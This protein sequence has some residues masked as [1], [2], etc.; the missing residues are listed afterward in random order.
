MDVRYCGY[1]CLHSTYSLYRFM[2][3]FLYTCIGICMYIYINIYTC[4]YI[5]VYV[6]LHTNFDTYIHK[7]VSGIVAASVFI[8]LIASI[9]ALWILFRLLGNSCIYY[10]YIW[11][12][13]SSWV[14]VMHF[15][16]ILI[17]MYVCMIV[18]ECLHSTYSLYRCPL[19]TTPIIR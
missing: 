15:I 1:K 8:A 2:H 3:I 19:D 10:T 12:Y 4:I 17:C 5:Y 9:A 6:C 11:D 14:Y 16:G 13:Y 7:W 18:C